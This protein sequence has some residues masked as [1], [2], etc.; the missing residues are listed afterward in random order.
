[1][2]RAVWSRELPA[3]YSAQRKSKRRASPHPC[4]K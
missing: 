2:F 3:E 1:L 4:R